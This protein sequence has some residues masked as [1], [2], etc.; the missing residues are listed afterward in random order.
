MTFD[1]RLSIGLLLLLYGV[2]LVLQGLLAGTLVLGVNINLWWGGVLVILG[3][4]MTYL[5][6]R[7]R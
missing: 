5:G 7:R 3:A 4:V 1:L 2:I 6:S